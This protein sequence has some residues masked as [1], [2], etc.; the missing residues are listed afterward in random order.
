VYILSG[1][2]SHLVVLLVSIFHLSVLYGYISVHSTAVT[3]NRKKKKRNKKHSET[4]DFLGELDL[5]QMG[6]LHVSS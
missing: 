1:G 4:T 5:M 3:Y 2:V 6:H